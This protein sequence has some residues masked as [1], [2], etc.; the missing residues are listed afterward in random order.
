VLS[1]EK[2]GNSPHASQK[3]FLTAN[4]RLLIAL[5]KIAAGGWLLLARIYAPCKSQ[6]IRELTSG[7][8]AGLVISGT[9]DLLDRRRHMEEPDLSDVP[10]DPRFMLPKRRRP[11]TPPP[12][13]VPADD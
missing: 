7:S 5:G 10:D 8:A 11:S 4:T 12:E 13:L 3:M 9:M 6:V 2:N 1:K